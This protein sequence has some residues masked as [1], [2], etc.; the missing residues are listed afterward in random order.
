VIVWRLARLA[1]VKLDGE[2]ARLAGGRWN[3]RGRPAVYTS[4]RLSLAALELL[5]HTEVTLVPADL[6]ACEIDIPDDV[7]VRSIELAELPHDWRRSGHP[8]CF[9]IGDQWLD[10][11]RAAVLRVPSAVVPEEWNYLINPRHR[12]ARS[13]EVVRQRTF[14]FDARLL[15]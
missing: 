15:G 2:G 12:A 1:H 11:G 6:V 5:V 13:I 10:D 8:Q 4:S 14:S 7:E 3:S 9:A